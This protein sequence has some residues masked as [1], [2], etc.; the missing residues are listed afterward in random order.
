MKRPWQIWTV[1]GVALGVALVIMA[2]LTQKTIALDRAE[3]GARAELDRARRQAVLDDRISQALWRMDAWLAPLIAQEAIRPAYAYDAVYQVPGAGKGKSVIPAANTISPILTQPSPFVLLHF[4]VNPTGDWSSP[5]SPTGLECSVA[6]ENGGSEQNFRVSGQRLATLKQQID[7]QHL[8]AQLPNTTLPTGEPGTELWNLNPNKAVGG[9]SPYVDN[10]PPAQQKDAQAAGQSPMNAAGETFAEPTADEPSPAGPRARVAQAPPTAGG[11]LVSRRG[12]RV[13]QRAAPDFDQQQT[14]QVQQ[15]NSLGNDARS[16]DLLSR[17]RS[18]QVVAQQAE[19][20]QRMQQG[21]L[22]PAPIKTTAVAGVSRP[23]W[24]GDQLVLAR[25]V[26]ADN[27]TLIQGVWLNWPSLKAWLQQ[28][29]ADLLPAVELAPV[30]VQ[31]DMGSARLLATLPVELIAR[32][33]E[34]ELGAPTPLGLPLVAAW[35]C[36]LLAAAAVAALLFGVVRLSERRAAFVSAVTHE[37]RT[38]LTT[39][40]L[41]TELLAENMVTEP[42]R[43]TQYLDTLHAEAD[44][45][46]HLVENVLSYARLERRGRAQRRET[47]TVGRLL[48]ASAERLQQ[49]AAQADLLVEIAADDMARDAVVVVDPVAVEQILFN[50]V[51]NACKYAAAASDRRLH[52]DAVIDAGA[53]VIAVRDH[54]PGIPAAMHREVFRPFSRPL[55]HATPN[56][57]GVGLGLALCQRL[58]RSIRGELRIGPCQGGAAFELRLPIAR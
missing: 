21:Y 10:L 15:A 39:F 7:P 19:A 30:N 9:N 22:Q 4:Q 11:P 5:Q 33:V 1:F 50:L 32:P 24:V 46:G 55:D 17:N 14:A 52:V 16:N 31:R 43:R 49:R 12:S 58:A 54:G 18:V 36:L 27:Q 28:S 51:D 41:Y 35:S 48:D 38:P 42:A 57:P 34:V 13:P 29:V 26:T 37:L 40:R 44:R 6:L 25:R 8:L 20:Q 23:I 56:I 45:L 47:T 3:A 2:W 53:A